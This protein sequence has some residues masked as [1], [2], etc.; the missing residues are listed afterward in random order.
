MSY[1]GVG[2]ENHD[3]PCSAK[4]HV[5]NEVG[6]LI[7]IPF[8]IERHLSPDALKILPN[9]IGLFRET[10]VFEVVFVRA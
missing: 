7:R 3:S 6:A 5:Q 9:E 2:L 10:A 8:L 1:D 4:F